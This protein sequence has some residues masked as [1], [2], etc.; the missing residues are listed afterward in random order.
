MLHAQQG[1]F[2]V[3]SRFLPCWPTLSAFKRYHAICDKGFQFSGFHGIVVPG[4]LHDSPCGTE[5]FIEELLELVMNGSFSLPP[6]SLDRSK[7]RFPDG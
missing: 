5:V 1:H 7:N 4:I 2:K 3:G 6:F